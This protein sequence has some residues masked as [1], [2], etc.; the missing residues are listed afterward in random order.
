MK[1]IEYEE[2]H[3]R[4]IEFW[5]DEKNKVSVKFLGMFSKAE[6]YSLVHLHFKVKVT[7]I[8]FRNMWFN[9]F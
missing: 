2:L 4:I 1:S 8:C 5:M 6:V 3:G 7:R 9:I